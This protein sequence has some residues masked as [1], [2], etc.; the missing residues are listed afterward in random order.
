LGGA[1]PTFVPAHLEISAAAATRATA[2]L[3]HGILG[4][5]SN[6]RSFVRRLV[7]G[8][9][10]AARLRWI[11]VDLRGHGDSSLV[12]APAPHTVDACA[13]DLARLAERLGVSVD[14]VIGHSFG[15]KVALAFAQDHSPRTRAAWF[16]DTPPGRQAEVSANDEIARMFAVLETFT[17]PLPGRAEVAWA[18]RSRGLSQSLAQWMTTNMRGTAETGYRWK[19][20]LPVVREL[21]ADYAALDLWPVVESPRPGLAVHGVLG[22]RSDRFTPEDRERL[23]RLGSTVLPDAGHWLHVDAPQAL[24]R[25]FEAAAREILD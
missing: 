12:P 16:L 8:S 10:A 21:V 15:G 3:V 11:L 5:A 7:D 14:L 9:P 18:L 4:S 2:F 25:R 20:D 24:A 23:A 13:A 6:W 19:F 17:E 22:Q 1:G